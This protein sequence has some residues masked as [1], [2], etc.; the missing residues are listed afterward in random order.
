ML[1]LITAS[2]PKTVELEFLLPPELP[3]LEA[4]AGQ[5]R[6]IVMSLIV[7]SAE[8]IGPAGGKVRVSTNLSRSG[9]DIFMEVKD[10]G[11]GMSE[12]TKTKMFD[13]FF[14]T[15]FIGRGLGLAAVSGM[16]RRHRGKMHVDTI[17]GQGTSFTVTF[18][19][20]AADVP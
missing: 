14:T 11:S 4:D 16:V 2:V 7:N 17:A 9:T 8:A 10:S 18:P 12:A 1:P 6:Q 15:R 13:P 5:V 19:A 3:W 20:V